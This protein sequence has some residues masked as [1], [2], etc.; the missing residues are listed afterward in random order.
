MRAL[1]SVDDIQLFGVGLL[2]SFASAWV[3]VAWLIRYVATRDFIPFA[4]YRIAFGLLVLVTA[5]TGAIDWT[6]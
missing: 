2:L 3:C 4:W 5:Y 6:A 1:L